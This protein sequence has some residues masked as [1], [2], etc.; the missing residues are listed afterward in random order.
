MLDD[1][2]AVLLKL[3]EIDEYISGLTDRLSN[4]DL[5]LSDLYHVLETNNLN[6]VQSYKFVKEMQKLCVERRVVKNDLSLAGTYKSHINKL[7]NKDNRNLLIVELNKTNN[8]LNK[9]YNNR[10]YTTEELTKIGI[11]KTKEKDNE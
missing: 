6:I 2:V 4:Y 1:I 9:E 7:I 10:V 11:V 5:K 3:N 8:R